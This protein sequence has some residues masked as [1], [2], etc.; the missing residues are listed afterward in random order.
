MLPK[1]TQHKIPSELFTVKPMRYR[2]LYQGVLLLCPTYLLAL[3]FHC[4]ATSDSAGVSA[5]GKVL[6]PY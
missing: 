1:A 2:L 4:L 3:D 5:L 6:L